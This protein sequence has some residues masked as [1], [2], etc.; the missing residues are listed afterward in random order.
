[1]TK[2]KNM[3]PICR[4]LKN[5]ESIIDCY[6]VEKKQ[7][8]GHLAVPSR[9][10]GLGTVT[11]NSGRL[12]TLLMGY[13]LWMMGTHRQRRRGMYTTPKVNSIAD[14]T[15][16]KVVCALACTIANLT[17]FC[18]YKAPIFCVANARAKLLIIEMV[19]KTHGL[20]ER[21]ETTLVPVLFCRL[22]F[23]CAV[24]AWTSF[25]C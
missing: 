14:N 5:R 17:S 10:S 23:V 8:S 13:C 9:K 16:W 20:Q 6:S 19:Y 21:K 3:L 11:L 25:D 15:H 4:A 22:H 24:S 1:M 2:K 7:K 18:R 12:T